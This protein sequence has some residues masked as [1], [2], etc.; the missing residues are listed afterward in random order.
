LIMIPVLVGNTNKRHEIS[1]VVTQSMPLSSLMR[2][3]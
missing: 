2:T 1:W 3:V